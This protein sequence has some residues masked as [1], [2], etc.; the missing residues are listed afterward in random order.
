MPDE[1]ENRQKETPKPVKR[2]LTESEKFSA[3]KKSPK[4]KPSTDF[5]TIKK[6]KPDSEKQGGE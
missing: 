4:P 3:D 5:I 6:S 1:K 2:A